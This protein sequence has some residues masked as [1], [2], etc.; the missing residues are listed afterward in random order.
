MTKGN[1]LKQGDKTPLKYRLFDADGEKLNIAGKSAQVRLVYPDFLTIGY[2]KDGLTV[3]QDDTVTFTIDSVIPPRMYHVEIIV[4]DQFI[5]PSRA[6]ETKFTI[7]NSS[8]GTE[9]NIIEIVGVDAVVRKAVDLINE[10]P[11]LIIDEDKLVTDIISNT[12]IGSIEEYYRQFNDVIKELSEEKDYHSLPEI[13][14]A[15][16]G[17]QTLSESLYNLSFDMFNTN[18]G[19]VT[20]NMVSDELLAQIAG[21]TAVNAVP[22]DGSL[23]TPKYADKSVTTN[24]M[25]D[26]TWVSINSQLA[27]KSLDEDSSQFNV[28]KFDSASRA[29]DGVS[30]TTISDGLYTISGGGYYFITEK[31]G[32]TGRIQVGDVVSVAFKVDNASS[33]A[34][35][36][37]EARYGQGRLFLRDLVYAGSGWFILEGIEIPTN[38]SDVRLRVDNR[39]PSDS[40]TVSN[41]VLQK[42]DRLMP[43]VV[44]LNEKTIDLT[45]KVSSIENKVGLNGYI[46]Y[47]FPEDFRWKDNPI[48]GKIFTDGKGNFEVVDFDIRQ[49]I[50]SGET[51]YV[52][53]ENGSSANNGLSIYSPLETLAQ[54]YNKPDCAIIR[55]AEGKYNR[56][57]GLYSVGPMDKNLAIIALEGHEVELHAGNPMQEWQLE[58]EHAGVYS[59]YRG[60][61]L[62]YIVDTTET[63]EYGAYKKLTKV[64]TI[65]EVENTPASYAH[66]GST[67][68]TRLHDSRKPDN[69][70][71]WVMTG[72]STIRTIGEATLYLEGITVYGGESAVSVMNEPTGLRPRV[73]GKDCDFFYSGAENR[74]AVQ[75]QGVYLSIFENCRAGLALKD[76]FNYHWRNNI[77]PLSIEI[78]CQGFENGNIEDANDQGSTTHDGGSIIRVNGAYYRNLGANI[79]E[80]STVGEAPTESLNLGCV[81]FESLTTFDGR[82]VNFDCYGGVNMW[83]DGCVGYGS[84]YNVKGNIKIRNSNFTGVL[85]PE[86]E[87]P[88]YY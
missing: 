25:S 12:G 80:D 18:L 32:T 40:V 84:D 50:P 83:V 54:A 17:Y 43:T 69:E 19:K 8:L 70:T 56:A 28:L 82:N 35:F 4:D 24:K 39:A 38:T 57:E 16:R 20:P 46:P 88:T 78:N 60:G 81:G 45:E 65:E 62:P 73:Y 86:G 37:F 3:A 10:D 59:S 5:F 79:A 27:I 53:K 11:S 22:A 15:R 74:D 2:E 31:V 61:S 44:S 30:D 49:Y 14:G 58:A 64:N 33:D 34:K 6:D 29:L 67:V 13:A 66:I 48:S 55:V 41:F 77:A 21:N 42:Y 85:N 51:Y 87:I 1:T 7:D 26:D 9:A 52:D 47:K 63:N 68:Y 75:L 76:G 71:V 23:T 72:V 36:E